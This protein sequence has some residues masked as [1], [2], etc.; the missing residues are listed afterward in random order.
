M[1]RLLVA[2]DLRRAWRN[3]VPYLIHLCLPLVIT[4]L[5][6]MIFGGANRQD[7][8]GLGRIKVAVVDEDDSAVTRLLRGVLNQEQATRHIEAKF[9]PRD[10]A[11]RLVTN[12]VVAAALIIPADFSRQYLV[13]EGQLTL[14]L[15]KNPAQQYH[16]AIVEEAVAVVTTALNAVARNFRPDLAE[17]RTL[18]SADRRPSFREVGDLVAK[19]GEKIDIAR[20]R[21]D[22][23]T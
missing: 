5:L 14:E 13:G 22:S 17:W 18:V 16:P 20:R 8:G 1:L 9:L 23:N 12:N 19:T 6:G 10:D 3:P 7:G 15:V 11:L 21:L 2:K 4:G